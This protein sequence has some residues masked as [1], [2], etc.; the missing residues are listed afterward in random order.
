MRSRLALGIDLGGTGIKM[1][2]V[3]AKGKMF[4]HHLVLTP[5]RASAQ[6]VAEL[7]SREALRLIKTLGEKT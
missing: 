1:A 2:F 7:V 4:R 6:D 5:Q 3:D